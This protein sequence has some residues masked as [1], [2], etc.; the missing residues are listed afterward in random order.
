MHADD[1]GNLPYWD[2]PLRQRD[3]EMKTL[4]PD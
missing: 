4:D 1:S 2:I 3:C